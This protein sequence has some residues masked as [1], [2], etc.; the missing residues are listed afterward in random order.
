MTHLE[1]LK[2]CFSH[3]RWLAFTLNADYFASDC[4][5]LHMQSLSNI[6]TQHKKVFGVRQAAIH[7]CKTL[8]SMKQVI[9]Q[10]FG[11]TD[12]YYKK[13]SQAEH[14]QPDVP[15][16]KSFSILLEVPN[17]TNTYSFSSLSNSFHV[18]T[19]NLKA[20]FPRSDF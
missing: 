7:T 1:W 13:I 11:N 19:A 17:E 9:Q 20:L 10:I 2:C 6:M 12:K 5:P 14:L 3:C 4:K 16:S 18:K 15:F 8:K